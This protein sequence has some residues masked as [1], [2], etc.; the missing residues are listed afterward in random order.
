[1]PPQGGH[2]H[3]DLNQLST[4][5][6][7]GGTSV[8]DSAGTVLAS[9][10]NSS[11]FAKAQNVCVLPVNGICTASAS[12]ITSQANIAPPEAE[13]PH[14]TQWALVCLG[15]PSEARRSATILRPTRLSWYPGSARSPSMS[16]SAMAEALHPVLAPPAA[17][18]VYARSL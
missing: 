3:Q 5:A 2:D 11:S 16:R 12:A 7:S 1:M 8:S 9:S 17:V 6:V 10:S 18:Y 4:A 15:S 14:P 13:N